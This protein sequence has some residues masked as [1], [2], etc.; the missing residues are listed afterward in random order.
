MEAAGM[1]SDDAVALAAAAAGTAA[2]PPKKDRRI[3]SWTPEEDD[4]L[5][6]QVA[7]HGIVNWTKIASQFR[8]KSGR[9]CRRRWNSY[10]NSDCKKGGW[11]P[12][13]DKLLCEAQKVYGNRWTEI[14]KVVS[15]RTDNAVKNRFSTLCKKRATNEALFKENSG[16]FLNSNKR[17]IIQNGCITVQT[18]ELSIPTKQMRY[19]I[20]DLKESNISEQ[21]TGNHE[22]KKDQLRSP[23]AVL[24]PNC[25]IA[26]GLL[27][28]NH[29]GNDSRTAVYDENKTTCTFFRKDDPKVT[30]LLQQAELL[31]S[32]AHKVNAENTKESLDDAWKGIQDYLAQTE[33]TEI[34]SR[35]ISGTEFVLD[36]FTDLI[37]DLKGTNTTGLQSLRQSE[38]H[39]N[40]EG[41]SE[42]STGLAEH[43]ETQRNEM[44][45]QTDNCSFNN[46]TEVNGPHKDMQLPSITTHQEEVLPPIKMPKENDESSCNVSNSQFASPLPTTPPFRS[47][48]DEIT[49]PEFTEKRFLLDLIGLPSPAPSPKSSQQPT[50]KKALLDSL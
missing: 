37:E 20:S 40:S 39:Q 17:V 34:L 45:H 14:A 43:F 11:S 15:G 28:Q 25:D 22:M 3:V 16:S 30:A 4:L 47:L 46:N 32:L 24:A 21:Y 50:C 42:Y 31:S 44:D 26:G 35:K 49:T 18:R 41:T 8:D 2:A 6:E 36:D 13:E 12:E 38:L 23:L 48:A 10:L 29:V 7:L 33:E 5:R 19:N 9:Q 1:N 27:T